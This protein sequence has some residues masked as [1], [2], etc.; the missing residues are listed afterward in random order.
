MV[1][2]I[3][4]ALLLFSAPWSDAEVVIETSAG[5]APDL[6]SLRL[7][8]DPAAKGH[9][10]DDGTWFIP[11]FKVDTRGTAPASS[12]F[13]SIRNEGDLTTNVL[14]E[15][16]DTAFTPPRQHAVRYVLI[17]D[18]IVSVNVRDVP[19]LDVDP[20]L[21]ARGILRITPRPDEPVAVDAFQV[22]GTNNFASGGHAFTAGDFCDL[23]QVRF[24]DFGGASGSVMTVLVNGPRGMGA[25][26]PPTI[27]G[28]VFNQQGQPVNNFNV[29]TN[30]WALEIP[31]LDLV[32]GDQR[33]GSIEL[34]LNATG[35]PGGVVS[36]VHSA[37]GRFSIG[38][39]GVCKD[40]I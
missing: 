20:D 15:Y 12:T 32:Q 4:A 22:D 39:E 7:P 17:A 38:A 14:V 9:E 24:L 31:L 3:A 25:A 29:R 18:Q 13:F 40:F 33:F 34:V 11:L 27:S 10:P 26:N 6:A 5:P 16:F 1:R 2:S 30:E 21:F 35:N 23:W 37:F 36:V 19:D 28:T 8:P